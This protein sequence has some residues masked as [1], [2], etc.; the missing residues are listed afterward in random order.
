MKK[1]IIRISSIV[2]LGIFVLIVYKIG[3]D[4][5]WDN[6]KKIT[7]G[8]FVILFFMR[9]FYWVLRTYSWKVILDGYGHRSS[10]GHLFACRMS[11]HAISHL[12]PS[13]TVG[14]EAAR[15]MMVNSSSKKISLASVIVDKTMEFLS[16]IAFAIIGVAIAITRIPMPAKYQILMI[17]FVG[18]ITFLLLL[19][20]HKQKQGFIGWIF[21]LLGKIRIKFKFVEKHQKKIKETDEYI[22]EFYRV[23]RKRFLHVFLLY[24]LLVLLW[25][26]EI[27]TTLLFINAK[28][29]SFL[30]SFVI[31]SLG[32]IAFAFPI[33]PASLGVYEATYVGIFALL[34][35]GTDVGLTLVLIRRVIALLWAGIG[36][37]G[38]MLINPDRQKE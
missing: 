33:V 29:I 4:Q 36:L 23:Q 11:S 5:I 13:A 10:F 14:G 26:A 17:S 20:T 35:L 24:S 31:V 34:R 38:M 25:T 12:T 16:L 3:P 19:I 15:I 30:D 9:L 1:K 18:F 22:S 6:I 2:G 28:G 7:L 27:H 32:S 8:N 21:K 37:L